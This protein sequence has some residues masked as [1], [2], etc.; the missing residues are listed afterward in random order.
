[1]IDTQKF[2]EVAANEQN[3]NWDK[4]IKRENKLY[5]KRNDIRTP[6]ERDYTRILHSLSYRRLK[7]KTQVFFTTSNDHVCTRIE[8]VNH[9]E[10]VSYTISRELGLNTELIRPLQ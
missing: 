4:L 2:Y 8:H 3:P 9:V 10:S 7:H 1:M 6:F 5:D